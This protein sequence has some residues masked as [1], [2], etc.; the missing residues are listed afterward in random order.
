MNPAEP[1]RVLLVER[2]LQGAPI[3]LAILRQSGYSTGWVTST[4][5]AEKLLATGTAVDILIIAEPEITEPLRRFCEGAKTR[6][7]ASIMIL[8]RST[9]LSRYDRRFCD[10]YEQALLGPPVWLKTLAQVAQRR[11]ICKRNSARNILNVDDN[12]FQRYAT[13]RMLRYDGYHVTEAGSGEKTLQLAL[14][15]PDLIVLDVN[16]P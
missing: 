9:S 6:Y 3:R 5:Q 11:E 4:E 10:G 12:E 7:Q 14:T 16:L 13:S 15:K 1:Y 2:D 8:G